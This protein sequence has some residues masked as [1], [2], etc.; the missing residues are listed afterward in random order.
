MKTC[1]RCENE[2]L[3]YYK[4]GEL[5]AVFEKSN[6][7]IKYQTYYCL[8]CQ[9]VYYDEHEVRSFINL[10]IAYALKQIKERTESYGSRKKTTVSSRN[11]S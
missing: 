2:I 11:S 4:T 5:K 9:I 8:R 3:P 6:K 1:P 7:M 10:R